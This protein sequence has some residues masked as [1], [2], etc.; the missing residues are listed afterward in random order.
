MGKHHNSRPAVQ[1]EETEVILPKVTEPET[2]T[3]PDPAPAPIIKG[4]VTGCYKLNVRR[5]P[6]A[7]A[8]VICEIPRDAVVIINEKKSKGEWYS[9]CTEAGIEGFCM[10]KYIS[11]SQ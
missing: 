1:V 10:K 2:V 5:A 8:T 3:E 11:V 4:V 9:V 7:N 6:S